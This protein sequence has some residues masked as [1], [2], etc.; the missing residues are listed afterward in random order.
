MATVIGGICIFILC[1]AFLGDIVDF[2][3]KGFMVVVIFGFCCAF[4]GAI[5]WG[6][7]YLFAQT[8]AGALPGFIIGCIVGAIIFFT[9]KSY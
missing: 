3:L 8:M 6:L 5:G 9:K 1:A 7:F 2:I 4:V